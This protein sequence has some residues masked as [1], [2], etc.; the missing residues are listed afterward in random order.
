VTATLAHLYEPGA[1]QRLH[2]LTGAQN[3]ES[4]HKRGALHLP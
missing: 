2:N 4:R 1:L 3:G